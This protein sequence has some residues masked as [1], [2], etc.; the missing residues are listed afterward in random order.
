MRTLLSMILFFSIQVSIS[1]ILSE[2]NRAIL[3][4]ELLEDL[5][6]IRTIDLEEILN[7]NIDTINNVKVS[8]V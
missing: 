2:K 4:D 5:M 1:Q 7:E 3:K 6:D 8:P